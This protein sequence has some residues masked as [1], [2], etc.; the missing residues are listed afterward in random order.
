MQTDTAANHGDT[1]TIIKQKLDA[2]D[3]TPG[4]QANVKRHYE[5]LE[6]LAATL[7]KLGMDERDISDEIMQV[8]QRYEQVLT[9]YIKAA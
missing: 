3:V 1:L 2:T 5:H 6:N 8:F 9:D 7:R 4:V